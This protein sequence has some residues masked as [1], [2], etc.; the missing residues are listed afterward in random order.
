MVE[1]LPAD[2]AML[3]RN[4]ADEAMLPRG[5]TGQPMVEHLP[6]D[7]AMMTRDDTDQ[8]MMGHLSPVKTDKSIEEHLP[9]DA[10]QPRVQETPMQ[11]KQLKKQLAAT[12]ITTPGQASPTFLQVND[13]SMGTSETANTLAI[14][15]D[16]TRDTTGHGEPQPEHMVGKRLPI[17]SLWILI[18]ALGWISQTLECWD[19]QAD[20]SHQE[21][22]LSEMRSHCTASQQYAW[23][24]VFRP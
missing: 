17:T 22:I 24:R 16:K 20:D 23:L 12:G 5:D 8:S 9:P 14:D 15:A 18:L 7:E 10:M 4:D 11:H 2:G 19:V 13:N 1:H 6:S 21:R 3:S